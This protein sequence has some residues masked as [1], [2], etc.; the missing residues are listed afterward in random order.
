MLDDAGYPKAPPTR[1]VATK[2]AEPAAPAAAPAAPTPLPSP[3]AAQA[4]PVP[5]S[6]YPKQ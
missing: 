3:D 6:G 5:G 1:R 4:L 2:A